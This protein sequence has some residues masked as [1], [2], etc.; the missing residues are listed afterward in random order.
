MITT[1]TI[2]SPVLKDYLQIHEPF[3]TAKFPEPK[4][5]TAKGRPRIGARWVVMAIILFARAHGITWRQ[6]PLQLASCHFLVEQGYLRSIPSKSTFHRYWEQITLKNIESLIK[7]VGPSHVSCEDEDM[8]IDSSGVE[9]LIGSWWRQAKWVKKPISKTSSIFRK[10][11]LAVA[12]PSRAIVSIVITA[13][14]THD[15][16][17]F[18]A[19]WTRMYQRVIRFVRRVHLD[20]AYWSEN[21]IN[22]LNQEGIMAVI[23]AKSNSKDH[24]SDSP[25]DQ[26]VRMQR[27]MPGLYRKNYKTYLRAEVEHVFGEVKMRKLVLRDYKMHNKYKSL[28][29]HF[30][31]YNQKL[32]LKEVMT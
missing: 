3:L 14:T 30:L 26:L 21:I 24:G 20:K 27:R 17:G 28:L 8:A 2:H 23:P 4:K 22:F 5:E 12:L 15:T 1:H 7:K 13:S 29:C 6:L 18:G 32:G 25:M 11:H 19:L 10:V 9:L 16:I 31:W